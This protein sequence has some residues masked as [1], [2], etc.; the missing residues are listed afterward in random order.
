MKLYEEQELTMQVFCEPDRIRR[1]SVGDLSV[2]GDN[3][4]ATIQRPHSQQRDYATLGG[5][6][7][8]LDSASTHSQQVSL[9]EIAPFNIR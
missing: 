7:L 2:G 1:D 3:T 9:L 8:P 6:I 4:Y 5:S